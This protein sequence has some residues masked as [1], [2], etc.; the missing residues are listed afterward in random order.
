MAPVG[1]AVA[2][3]VAR[4]DLL[5]GREAALEEPF[6][7]SHR[8][9]HHQAYFEHSSLAHTPAHSES[10]F[11]GWQLLCV[12][13]ITFPPSKNF[14]VYLRSFMR[15]K[16]TQK[17][18]RIDVMARYCIGKLS[19]IA[20]RGPR[21]KPPTTQE[22]EIASD[23]AFNPSTFGESLDAIFKMQER[24]YPTAKVP[25]VLPFLSDGILAL[26]GMKAEGI[27][28]VPG[29]ADIVADLRARI[30]RGYYNLEG[31]DDP[32]VPASL[33]KLWLRELQEPLIP[34][35]LYDECI[36]ASEDPEKVVR[37]VRDKLPTVN[38]RV[39]LFVISFLQMFLEESVMA[40]T[41]MTA[42]NMALVFAPNILRCAI[43]SMAVVFANA[44]WVQFC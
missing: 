41:K 10:V 13:L 17:V 27:F 40:T 2:W 8:Y 43:E 25:I 28:R 9:H 26:G 11:K 33:F 37:I 14:E 29:E 32:H 21:G 22:I 44:R 36:S 3:R 1:R 5:P 19:V 24:T 30:D 31:I 12:L 18:G 15:E 35:E 23:A 16:T 4:R 38:R 34:D 42:P 7:V 20:K 39:L 6:S